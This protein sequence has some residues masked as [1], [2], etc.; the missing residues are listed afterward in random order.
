MFLSIDGDTA[1]VQTNRGGKINR[2]TFACPWIR[3]ALEPSMIKKDDD[4]DEHPY[5]DG[6]QGP[7]EKFL[8]A[9]S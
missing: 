2:S 8:A 1:I 7:G 9:R 4:E 6:I 3:S 5:E